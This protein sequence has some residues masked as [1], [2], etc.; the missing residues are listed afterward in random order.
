MRA[1]FRVATQLATARFAEMA[2][3]VDLQ[4]EE[5]IAEDRAKKNFSGVGKFFFGFG[6]VSSLGS[7]PGPQAACSHDH[8][9]LGCLQGR[10]L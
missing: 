7:F 8:L 6:A 5:Q 4:S 2:S 10:C 9:F 3:G 1:G